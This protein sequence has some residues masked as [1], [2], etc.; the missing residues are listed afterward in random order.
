MHLSRFASLFSLALWWGSLT[1]LGFIVVPML[2]AHMDTMQAAGRMAAKLFN[3][4]AYVS[5]GCAA[6]LIV[7]HWGKE[8]WVMVWIGLGLAASLAVQ[9]IVAPQILARDNLRLWHGIG[10][11]LYG[12]QWVCA[13]VLVYWRSRLP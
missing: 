12:L 3:V 11:G 8:R 7:T 2:F 13:T 9:W 4:Q 10:S 1:T 6:V 5:L